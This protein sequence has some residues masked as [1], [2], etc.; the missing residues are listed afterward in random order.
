MVGF[1][2]AVTARSRINHTYIRVIRV[3]RG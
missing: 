3:I 2:R 1:V